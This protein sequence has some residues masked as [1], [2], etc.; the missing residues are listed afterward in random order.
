MSLL[1]K[2]IGIKDNENAL[3]YKSDNS[4]ALDVAKRMK[5]PLK[6]KFKKVEDSYNDILDKTK[7]YYEEEKEMKD[8]VRCIKVYN[9]LELGRQVTPNDEPFVVDHLRAEQLVHV[10]V[11]KVVEENVEKVVEMPK[12][13]KAEETVKKPRTTKRPIAKRKKI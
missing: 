13:E 1:R 8:R 3:F 11:C 4:N 9:D 12:Q 6:F 7:S 5:T 10:G 2:E